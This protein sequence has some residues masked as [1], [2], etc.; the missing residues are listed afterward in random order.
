MEVK[1]VFLGKFSVGKTSLIERITR[2]TFSDFKEATIGAAFRSYRNN[3]IRFNIWDTSGSERYKSL[4]PMYYRNA[5]V[6]IVV[7]DLKDNDT[8]KEALDWVTKLKGQ[9]RVP[10][11]YLIGNKKDLVK[12]EEEVKFEM[13]IEK[14]R[15]YLVSAKSGENIQKFFDEMCEH[16]S[17]NVT[18]DEKEINDSGIL[19]LE[20]EDD[21]NK[22]Y[23]NCC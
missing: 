10:L 21:T 20:I 12:E 9:A 7:Y 16:I 13:E 4:T 6:A 15:K 11:I 19:H 14:V 23:L 17:S 2:N 8:Y 5:D 1:V 22:K 3:N 18:F